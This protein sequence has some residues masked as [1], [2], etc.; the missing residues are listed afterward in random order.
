MLVFL[1]LSGCCL[2][3]KTKRLSASLLLLNT[4]QVIFPTIMGR[5][6]YMC[7]HAGSMVCAVNTINELPPLS[8]SRVDI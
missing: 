1:L 8:V 3:E 4:P 5:M 7:Q 6:N 2:Y